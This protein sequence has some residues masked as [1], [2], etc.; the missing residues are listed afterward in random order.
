M[1]TDRQA[2]VILATIPS[3]EERRRTQHAEDERVWLHRC[4]RACFGTAGAFNGVIVGAHR[5]VKGMEGTLQ[6][7]IKYEDGDRMHVGENNAAWQVEAYRVSAEAAAEAA[8]AKTAEEEKAAA[9]FDAE[10]PL[11]DLEG[12]VHQQAPGSGG[13]QRLAHRSESRQFADAARRVLGK[14]K[15]IKRVCFVPG[16]GAASAWQDVAGVTGVT[17]RSSRARELVIQ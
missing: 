4:V 11:H 6:L 1:L 7:L 16:E 13:K 17:G 8:V 9:D 2:A 12:M 3:F 14:R 15:R 5:D 10:L